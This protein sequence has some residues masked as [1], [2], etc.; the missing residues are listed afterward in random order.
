MLPLPPWATAVLSVGAF[1]SFALL[2]ALVRMRSGGK[3]TVETREIAAAVV[4]VG[5]GL[6]LFGEFD[7][8]AYGDFRLVRKI[9]AEANTPAGDRI[10]NKLTILNYE[11]ISQQARKEGAGAIERYLKSG[12]EAL[13][14]DLGK[15]NYYVPGV[16]RQY[17][18]RLTKGP[19]LKYIVFYEPSGKMKAVADAR[20]IAAH[21]RTPDAKLTP[22]LLTD[23]IAKPDLAR[24]KGLPGYVEPVGVKSSTREALTKMLQ[25]DADFV[26]IMD[27]Q[28]RFV[29]VARGSQ[30]IG[31]LVNALA[32][33]EAR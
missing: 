16:V 25:F 31:R 33:A 6:F 3:F 19:Y 12:V 5:I 17:I 23:W 30:L 11:P 9:S 26:P 15:K 7:E 8:I 20:A 2:L 13:S 29:G 24:L 28:G 4:A 10:A 27:E 32:A 21:F 14:F 1:V 22:R 18:E